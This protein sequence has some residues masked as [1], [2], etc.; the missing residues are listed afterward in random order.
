M[1]SMRLFGTL[2][3]SVGVLLG[4]VLTGGLI[5]A[6]LESDVYFGPG[7]PSDA[8]LKT[9]NCP[10][11]ISSDE[12]GVISVEL[13]NTTDKSVEQLV[14]LE[15]SNPGFFN[16]HREK[17]QVASGDSRQV[18][19]QVSS[20]NAVFGRLILIRAYQFPAYKTPSRSGSCGILLIDL[21]GLTGTQI[22]FLSF[23]LVLTCIAVGLGVWRAANRQAGSDS[24]AAS[25]AMFAVGATVAVGLFLGYSGLWLPGILAVVMTVLMGAEMVR[26]FVI[27]R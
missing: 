17:Y 3:F 4:L 15:V 7:Y 24:F 25:R 19:W 1:K 10:V 5:L 21:L 2:I 12:V 23:G 16:T 6:G 13:V 11:M 20:Q 18:E 26:Q 27:A 14:L 22:L 8:G 9:L